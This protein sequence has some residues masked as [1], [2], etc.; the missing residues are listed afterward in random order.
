MQT[1]DLLEHDP[2]MLKGTRKGPML[3]AVRKLRDVELQDP[4][5]TFLLFYWSKA[6]TIAS[7]CRGLHLAKTAHIGTISF[8]TS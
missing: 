1:G 5:K 3:D 8:K 7:F 6:A 4:D 2:C